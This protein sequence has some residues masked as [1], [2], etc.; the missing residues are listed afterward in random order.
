VPRGRSAIRGKK[1]KIIKRSPAP[2][3]SRQREQRVERLENSKRKPL[4]RA[5]C[6][7]CQEI[8]NRSQQTTEEGIRVLASQAKNSER[9]TVFWSGT[10]AGPKANKKKKVETSSATSRRLVVLPGIRYSMPQQA[11]RG[12]ID[13]VR[14]QGEKTKEKEM[15]AYRGWREKAASSFREG[16]FSGSK[17][18]QPKPGF[19]ARTRKRG[20]TGLLLHDSR[21][22][23]RIKE[24][25]IH[26]TE[27]ER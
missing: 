2:G 8:K 17:R 22:K 18:V 23:V 27:E 1:K 6:G 11:K 20:R 5:G 12:R 3:C 7:D 24:L 13:H 26:R 21:N 16:I 9:G 4:A 25:G 15:G 14:K 10:C 19:G